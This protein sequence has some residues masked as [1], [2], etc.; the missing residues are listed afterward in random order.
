MR[1]FNSVEEISE[2]YGV[3][4]NVPTRL[5][6][7]CNVVCFVVEG[8]FS[9]RYLQAYKENEQGLFLLGYGDNW[10]KSS[11]SLEDELESDKCSHNIYI[12]LRLANKDDFTPKRLLGVETN[13]GYI[14][15]VVIVEQFTECFKPTLFVYTTESLSKEDLMDVHTLKY[16]I[17]DESD[18]TVSFTDYVEMFYDGWCNKNEIKS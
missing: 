9:I 15:S 17:S 16:Y 1:V 6:P 10:K 18:E 5:H 11:D 14:T 13:C 7:D 3:D 12:Y 8:L 4:V 2:V